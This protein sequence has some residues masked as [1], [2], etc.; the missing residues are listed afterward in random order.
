MKAKLTP[1]DA[2]ALR[3]LLEYAD[4]TDKTASGYYRGLQQREDELSPTAKRAW[5]HWSLDSLNKELEEG[6]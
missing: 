5:F 6:A 2:K 3:A 4:T 1:E